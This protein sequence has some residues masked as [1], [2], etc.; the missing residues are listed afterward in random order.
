MVSHLIRLRYRLMW[1]GFRRSTGAMIGAIFSTL[2]YLYLIGM[3]YFAAIG[4]VMVS[5]ETISYAQR[6]APF[7]LLCCL[8]HRLLPDQSRFLPRVHHRCENFR[9]SASQISNWF[10]ACSRGIIAPTGIGT[11]TLLLT[12]AVLWG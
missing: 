1:N 5:P 11:F 4:I 10:S 8:H 9:P 6:G 2:G 12:G 3:A 7:I